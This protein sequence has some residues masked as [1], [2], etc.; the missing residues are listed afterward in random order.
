M[1]CIEA[2]N[3]FLSKESDDTLIYALYVPICAKDPLM[4]KKKRMEVA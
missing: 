1:K 2:M 4:Q 3:G